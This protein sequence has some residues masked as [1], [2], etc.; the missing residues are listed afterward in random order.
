M[1]EQKRSKGENGEPLG[2]SKDKFSSNGAQDQ[3]NNA[4][5]RIHI[6]IFLDM[7]KVFD[8]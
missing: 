2:L 4:S 5:M 3:L 8:Y 1:M 7:Y 6:Y